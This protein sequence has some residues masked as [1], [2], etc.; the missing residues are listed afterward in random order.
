MAPQ[1]Y[2]WT[3]SICSFT[4]VIQATGTDPYLTRET[5]AEIIGVPECVDSSWGLKSSECMI[6]AFAKYGLLAKEKW[7]TYDEAYAICRETTGIFNPIGMYHVMAIRGVGPDYIWVANSARGYRQI[8]DTMDR[9]QF[10]S[11][12]PTKVIYLV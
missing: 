7:V 11:Y 8:W 5:A 6:R 1:I 12:G 2:N 9:N 10:N 4:W 3:C